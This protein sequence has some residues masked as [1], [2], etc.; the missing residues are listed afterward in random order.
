MSDAEL[1]VMVDEEM[2][3]A[4]HNLCELCLVAAHQRARAAA[5]EHYRMLIDQGHSPADAAALAARCSVQI[6][7][8]LQERDAHFETAP[9]TQEIDQIVK[10]VSARVRVELFGVLQ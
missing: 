3:R 10:R 7:A 4:S 5:P 9:T 8:A 2:I 6:S 1:L